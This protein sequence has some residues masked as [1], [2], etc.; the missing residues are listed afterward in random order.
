MVGSKMMDYSSI[1]ASQHEFTHNIFYTFQTFWS[2]IVFA[3]LFLEVET[4]ACY[5]F[6]HHTALP[7]KSMDFFFKTELPDFFLILLDWKEMTLH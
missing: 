6:K 4:A 7:T 5:T 1:Y 3:L 2:Y